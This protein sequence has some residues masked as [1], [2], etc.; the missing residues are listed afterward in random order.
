MVGRPEDDGSDAPAGPSDPVV[1]G[2]ESSDPDHEAGPGAS[3]ASVWEV[4]GREVSACDV[5]AWSV[6]A[7]D[8]DE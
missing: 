4:P 1:T 6:G 5:C 8:E 2:A 7:S 3:R